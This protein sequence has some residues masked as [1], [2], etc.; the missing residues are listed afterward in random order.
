[1]ERVR[2]FFLAKVYDFC[3]HI[4][5]AD[6]LVCIGF[7]L[8]FC[9]LSFPA[10]LKNEAVR[11]SQSE[12]KK[13]S[14]KTRCLSLKVFVAPV[15]T[16]WKKFQRRGKQQNIIFLVC[17]SEDEKLTSFKNAILDFFVYLQRPNSIREGFEPR[18]A[19][20][21]MAELASSAQT[22]IIQVRLLQVP[23]DLMSV[24]ERSATSNTA[25]RYLLANQLTFSNCSLG[26]SSDL[27]CQGVGVF[28]FQSRLLVKRVL[29]AFG[30]TSVIN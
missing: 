21:K 8:S 26:S 28:G 14:L 10:Q 11:K 29:V 24:C 2:F 13:Q 17:V 18:P 15:S 7:V 22:Y 6:F 3:A 30:T 25:P 27:F 4:C 23:L 20:S 9:S 12:K 1:M 16:A 19:G 5:L